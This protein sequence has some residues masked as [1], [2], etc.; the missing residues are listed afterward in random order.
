MLALLIRILL[1]LWSASEARVSREAEI[2]V[3]CQQLMVLSRRSRKPVRLRN[4]DRLVFVWRYR[5][6]PSLLDTI[7]IVKPGT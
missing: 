4:L 1:A 6:L 5:L 3:L 7:I 2:L